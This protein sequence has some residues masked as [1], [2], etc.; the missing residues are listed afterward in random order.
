LASI[1]LF[2]AAAAPALATK[3]GRQIDL[4]TPEGA[5]LAARK[6]QCSTRDNEPSIYWFRGEAFSRVPGER[7][8]KLFNVEGMNIRTC[9]TV[10]DPKRGEGWR[11]VSRELLFYVDPASGELLRTWK[12]PWTG[13]TVNVLQTANDPVN[14]RP[15]FP[16]G[17]D[18]TPMKWTATVTGDY[19][20]QTLTVPLFY[21]NPLGGDYQ[22]Y[23]GGTY[24]ATEMFNF[25][26]RISDITDMKKPTA[27]TEVGWVRMASWLPWMEMGDRAGLVYVHAAG[28]KIE[29]FEQLPEVMRR[30]IAASYPTYTAPPAGDDTRENETSWTYFKKKFPPTPKAR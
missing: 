13:V 25:F 4:G 21:E 14:Q 2:A 7:D 12:N 18:G 30:E 24:H 1:A 23:I 8:R 17:A 27:T 26:G 20:W 16:Y 3:A 28:R 15:V 9:V 22:K 19:W 5:N 29:S 11:L 10:K 6:I